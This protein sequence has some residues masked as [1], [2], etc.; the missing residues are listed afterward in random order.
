MEFLKKIALFG[1][2][3]VLG[4]IMLKLVFGVLGFAFSMLWMA[5]TLLPLIIIA[6]PIY[7]YLKRKLLPNHDDPY[8]LR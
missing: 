6:I 8:R 4:Y 2:A 7:L 5:I 3:I 1:G